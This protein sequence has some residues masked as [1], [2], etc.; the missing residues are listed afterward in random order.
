MNED[1]FMTPEELNMARNDP[2]LVG[3]LQRIYDQFLKVLA[4]IH[5][6]IN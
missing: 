3:K 4:K 5:M 2:L 1:I 6:N